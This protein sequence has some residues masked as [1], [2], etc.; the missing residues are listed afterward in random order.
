MPDRG[1]PYVANAA[2]HHQAEDG[3]AN[4]GVLL[5]ESVA[6]VRSREEVLRVCRLVFDAEAKLTHVGAQVLDIVGEVGA[7]YAR[8]E[9]VVADGASLIPHEEQ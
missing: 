5:S 1:R 3:W 2:Q 4:F 8:K 9:L 6:D 7:P